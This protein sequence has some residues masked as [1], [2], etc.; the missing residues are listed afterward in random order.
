MAVLGRMAIVGW[1]L[2]LESAVS[3][4]FGSLNEP[5]NTRRLRALYRSIE[6]ISKLCGGRLAIY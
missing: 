1:L 2:L 3:Q 5:W 6:F 4:K